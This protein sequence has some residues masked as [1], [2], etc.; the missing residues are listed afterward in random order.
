[1]FLCEEKEK[2]STVE[3]YSPA[4]RMDAPDKRNLVRFVL[5]LLAGRGKEPF[6]AFGSTILRLISILWLS[7]FFVSRFCV[8]I[9][10][11]QVVVRVVFVDLTFVS[12]SQHFSSFT[13]NLPVSTCLEIVE[14][15]VDAS[16]E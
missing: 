13:G 3:A 12:Q 10:L 14:P 11:R 1:M 9:V 2:D 6:F 5:R 8:L 16:V 15:I 7:R 4:S